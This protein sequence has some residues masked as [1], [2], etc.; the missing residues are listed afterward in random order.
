MRYFNT[1]D[2]ANSMK[3]YIIYIVSAIFILVGLYYEL[4]NVFVNRNTKRIPT[5]GLTKAEFLQE[6]K[7]GAT[8]ILGFTER[9]TQQKRI[10]RIEQE[11]G[12]DSLYV[13]TTKRLFFESKGQ[14][15]LW[16][17]I[18]G[19]LLLEDTIIES[20]ND[21]I[22]FV[23]TADSFIGLQ[24]YTKGS[25]MSE[26]LIYDWPF[27][28]KG[29][30]IFAKAEFYK[31]LLFS[32]LFYMLLILMKR[33]TRRNLSILMCTLVI[34]AYVFVIKIEFNKNID[35]LSSNAFIDDKVSI[36]NFHHTILIQH[37]FFIAGFILASTFY[38]FIIK[39]KIRR[40]G[41]QNILTFLYFY[42]TLI[43]YFIIIQVLVNAYYTSKYG[44]AG[45][46]NRRAFF[47]AFTIS[48][49]ITL[50]QFLFKKFGKTNS[51]SRKILKQQV[52]QTKSELAALQSS[53]NPHFLYNSLNS[54]AT[55]AKNDPERTEEMS[56]ALSQFY[57]YTTNRESKSVTS[58]KEELDMLEH[59]LNVEKI[60]F[61]D[62]LTSDIRY[63][64]EALNFSLPYFL[65]QPL[66]ENAIKYG[67]NKE[68][69]TINIVLDITLESEG[70][71]I[72]VSDSGLAFDE[73]MDRGYGLKSV[74]KK[75]E[76]IY[77]DQ[78][79]IEFVNEPKH[80]LI[81]IQR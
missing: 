47:Y 5:T 25:T 62:R 39:E 8:I 23:N 51:P 14:Q 45:L 31:I 79:T 32:I 64:D 78:H 53:V 81:T 73:N 11:I 10:Y 54:I 49:L 30:L 36:Y 67:Y 65:L 9:I 38:Y 16:E 37:W 41:Y 2:S 13:S 18:K 42:G 21:F 77:P 74:M 46:Q 48:I 15:Y 22:E 69:N 66:V 60:R 28:L 52:L 6:Q 19:D 43:G 70:L 80:V 63:N 20:K 71:V 27:Y 68:T 55:L 1:L 17:V 61:E 40:T 33:W 26:S 59:Y 75:L 12:F 34:I 44:V 58:V 56:L 24:Q 57:K 35:V 50:G 29:Y 4:D 76:L 72:K 7:M 3:R